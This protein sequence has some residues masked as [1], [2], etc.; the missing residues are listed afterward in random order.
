MPEETNNASTDNSAGGEVN[1]TDSGIDLSKLDSVEKLPK[2]AQDELSRARNDAATYRTR[3]RDAKSE[4]EAEVRAEIQNEVKGLNDKVADLEMKLS[5]SDLKSL[6][7]ETALEV[8]VP[9]EHLKTFADRLRGTTAEELKA[10]AEEAK[11]LFG[12]GNETKAT[13]PT[14]GLGGSE[15]KK[16]AD[17][18]LGD[19]VLGKL[20]R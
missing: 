11:K 16:S 19:Y 6:K 7:L 2:W 12:L 13:D 20:S 3:L 8:G 9:G 18:L 4:V 15:P 17:N 1:K 14:A 5:D 10:D